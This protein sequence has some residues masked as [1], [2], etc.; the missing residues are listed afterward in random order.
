MKE[1]TK[2]EKVLRLKSGVQFYLDAEEAEHLRQLLCAEDCPRFVTYKGRLVQTD[3]VSGIFDPV[4]FEDQ[5]RRRN[6]QWKDNEGNWHDRGERI[7]PNCKTV[8]PEGKFC[9][10]CRV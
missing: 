8:L 9:G 7:C 3:E 2:P 5:Q 1:L 10:S 4:D 6:G